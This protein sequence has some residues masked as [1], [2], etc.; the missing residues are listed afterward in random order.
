MW[1]PE[2]HF[3]KEKTRIQT[4]VISLED[5][6]LQVKQLV[7]WQVSLKPGGLAAWAMGKYNVGVTETPNKKEMIS[8]E[9]L[10]PV[11]GETPMSSVQHRET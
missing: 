10:Q 4:Q 2:N 1:I 7:L 8:Q 3:L 11:C 6:E 9:T 5:G